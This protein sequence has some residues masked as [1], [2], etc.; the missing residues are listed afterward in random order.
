MP[1]GDIISSTTQTEYLS[2]GMNVRIPPL[3]TS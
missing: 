1:G 2:K 3:I